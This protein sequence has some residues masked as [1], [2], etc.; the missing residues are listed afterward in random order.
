MHLNILAHMLFPFCAVTIKAIHFSHIHTE[1][2][3]VL[4]VVALCDLNV[5]N[6]TSKKTNAYTTYAV[7]WSERA[8]ET[9]K[10]KDTQNQK[11]DA[12]REMV[13]V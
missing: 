7:T 2:R 1:A 9:R 8:Q 11:G 12:T 6:A 10:D 5:Y 13:S 4:R 3:Q